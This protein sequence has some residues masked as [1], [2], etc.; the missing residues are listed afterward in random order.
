VIAYNRA[1]LRTVIATDGLVYDTTG[2][3]LARDSVRDG[4]SGPDFD[5]QAMLDGL[6]ANWDSFDY[7]SGVSY[8]VWAY[9][10][11]PHPILDT[12]LDAK[13]GLPVDWDSVQSQLQTV[14]VHW[15][16]VPGGKHAFDVAKAVDV[17]LVK[18]HVYYAAVRSLNRAGLRHSS[19]LRI[20]GT[21]PSTPIAESPSCRPWP[22]P[23]VKAPMRE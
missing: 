4:I 19:L 17:P 2:P 3:E 11:A 21:M 22:I 20:Q 1:G 16:M 7:E 12:I 23:C 13:S 8:H 15:E 6:V 18:N 9:T 10:E 14:H 5:Q